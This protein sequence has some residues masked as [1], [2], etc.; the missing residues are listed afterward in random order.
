ME[1]DIWTVIK[2]KKKK[3]RGGGGG[4]EMGKKVK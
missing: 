4:K 2:K 1:E 3:K